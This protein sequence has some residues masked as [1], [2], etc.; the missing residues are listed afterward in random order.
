MRKKKE[1]IVEYHGKEIQHHPSKNERNKPFTSSTEM[2]FP[3][4]L[5]TPHPSAPIFL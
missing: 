4:V 2:S 3:C 1:S 5:S